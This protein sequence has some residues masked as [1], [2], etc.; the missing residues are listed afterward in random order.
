MP[1][2]FF[3][4]D[5][6]YREVFEET[7]KRLYMLLSAE[8]FDWDEDTERYKNQTVMDLYLGYMA[9]ENA[10][11]EALCALRDKL[12]M[13]LSKHYTGGSKANHPDYGQFVMA[14]D[15]FEL[16]TAYREAGGVF[17]SS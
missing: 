13:F 6:A 7:A 4:R 14:P 11:F 5:E 16:V 8:D 2:E 1:T 3:K 10:E 17:E 12:G 9:R 15:I